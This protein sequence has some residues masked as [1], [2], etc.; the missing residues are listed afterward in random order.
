MGKTKIKTPRHLHAKYKLKEQWLSE[1]MDLI[2]DHCKAA[3]HAPPKHIRVSTGWPSQSALAA[4]ARR[5]GEA[6]TPDCSADG[7]HEIIISL[8]LDDAA[9]VLV[10]LLHEV[11]HTIAGVEH[12]HR[13]A[14]ITVAKAVGL[15]KPWTATPPSEDLVPTVKQWYK[16]LGQYPHS[17]LDGAKDRKKQSTRL[18]KMACEDC[19]CVIRV[20]NKWIEEYVEF[21]CPCGGILT[22]PE[23]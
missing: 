16:T 3:G 21:P 12:G 6:W 22:E 15:A 17:R 11:C 18:L 19:G 2:R 4:K 9:E 8:Y 20:S 14:F 10:T 1:A 7:V 23:E 13:K 5:V